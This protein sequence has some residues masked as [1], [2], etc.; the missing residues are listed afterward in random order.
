MGSNARWIGLAILVVAFAGLMY[1]RLTLPLAEPDTPGAP[2]SETVAATQDAPP[3]EPAPETEAAAKPE[4]P[5]IRTLPG[6]APA[7]EDSAK[8]EKPKREFV[9]KGVI[10]VSVTGLDG[11]PAA[12]ANVMIERIDWE[13]NE[14]PPAEGVMQENFTGPD[15]AVSFDK[16]P[17]GGYV[18][19]AYTANGMQSE[20]AYLGDDQKVENVVLTLWESAPLDGHV[21]D[22]NGKGVANALVYVYETDRFAIGPLT[23]SRATQSRQVADENGKFQFAAL[24]TGKWKLYAQADGFASSVTD[25]LTVPT[26]HVQIILGDGGIVSGSVADALTGK[27]VPGTNVAVLT[28][29]ARDDH[30]VKADAEGRFSIAGIRAGDIRLTVKDH[31]VVPQSGP[32]PA[33]VIDG[34]ETGGIELRVVPGGIVR[35]RFYDKDTGKGIIGAQLGAYSQ[36]EAYESQREIESGIDGAYEVRG[37]GSAVYEIMPREVEGYPSNIFELRKSLGVQAGQVYEG[38]DFAL[39]RGLVLSGR[40]VDDQGVGIP[41][42]KLNAKNA[43]GG[44]YYAQDTADELGRFELAGLGVGDVQT[45][46]YKDGY[47]RK[48]ANFKLESDGLSGVEIVL[49]SEAVVTGIVVDTRNS[50]VALVPLHA[51]AGRAF[52]GNQVTSQPDGTFR[53]GGLGE[54]E[55]HVYMARIGQEPWNGKAV[56]TVTLKAG[57]TLEGLRLVYDFSAGGRVAGRGTDREGKPIAGVTLDGWSQNGG[58]INTQ[59]DSDGRYAVE[60]LEPGFVHLEAQHMAY[61]SVSFSASVDSEDNDFVMDGRG[62]ISGRV[63]DAGNGSA[64]GTFEIAHSKGDGADGNQYYVDYRMIVESSGEFLIENVEVGPNTVFAKAEGFAKSF[65]VVPDV[66]AGETVSGVELRLDSAAAVEGTVVDKR[67]NA[68]AGAMVFDGPLPDTWVRDRA[69]AATTDAN[70]EF[71]IETMSPDATEIWAYHVDYL[72]GAAAVSLSP[73]STNR[74]EIVLPDGGTVEGLVRVGGAPKEG[75]YVNAYDQTNPN[76]QRNA[77]TG[78]DGRYRIGGLAPGPLNIG[79]HVSTQNNR[80]RSSNKQVEVDEGMSATVNF[81]FNAD[82][83][84]EGYV[85]RSGEPVKHAWIGVTIGSPDDGGE[86]VGTETDGNGYFRIEGIASGAATVTAN[87][88]QGGSKRVQTTLTS[89]TVTRVDI[90][91][92][93]GQRVVASIS[94]L[95]AGL[96][97]S[98]VLLT[99][100]APGDCG[101]LQ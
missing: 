54:G 49:G 101:D 77:Q 11:K 88:N 20:N 65:V 63:I 7:K 100:D 80:N 70:G 68:I 74:V 38:I 50:P 86:N 3:A 99:A 22:G 47:G 17:D 76:S 12:N 26:G 84:L 92:D 94:G 66:R 32:V 90:D 5:R 79:A 25:W 41:A 93:S 29:F 64:L 9:G 59:T 91:L 78:A 16:L 45:E 33:T 31:E 40:V 28:G 60:G 57:E 37:L 58:Q 46:A 69:A 81:D 83:T 27:P 98:A 2:T 19:R 14:R 36:D 73:N 42:A 15:G 56:E 48:F 21:V 51:R 85:T 62:A 97:G 44:G 67:G 95:T 34:R 43:S 24:W 35:G 10:N 39:D 4:R 1:W 61:S 89:G 8:K 30:Q 96:D 72:E 87:D 52:S 55:Y 13:L 18:A 82:A 23:S 53:L 71:R 75:V 6:E